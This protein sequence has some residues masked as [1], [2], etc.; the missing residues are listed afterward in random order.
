M[1]VGDVEA[2]ATTFLLDLRPEGSGS[3][4]QRCHIMA[5]KPRSP[6]DAGETDA[7]PRSRLLEMETPLRQIEGVVALLVILSQATEPIEPPALAVLAAVGQSGHEQLLRM[8]LNSL[9]AVK[10]G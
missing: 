5:R 10:A 4:G 2:A 8:W 6:S 9:V 1:P 7:T 3:C